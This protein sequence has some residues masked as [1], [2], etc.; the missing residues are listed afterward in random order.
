MAL[1]LGA[2]QMPYRT[3]PIQRTHIGGTVPDANGIV[4][5]F[6]DVGSIRGRR[7]LAPKAEVT[8]S[9]GVVFAS[10]DWGCQPLSA[11]TCAGCIARR[12]LK[13]DGQLGV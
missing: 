2:D 7:H 9:C 6:D 5:T 3:G 8:A 10:S 1:E 4:H 13:L 12:I 11:V